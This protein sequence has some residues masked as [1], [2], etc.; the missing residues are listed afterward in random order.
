MAKTFSTYVNRLDRNWT[1][2][3]SDDAEAMI[4]EIGMNVRGPWKKS[5][6]GAP[7]VSNEIAEE[8]AADLRKSG[9]VRA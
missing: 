9:W 3:A 2:F 5:K 6:A 1:V 4:R 8:V 7:M